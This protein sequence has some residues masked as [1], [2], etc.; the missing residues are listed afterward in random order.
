MRDSGAVVRAV[1]GVEVNASIVLCHG[2][3]AVVIG[4]YLE[5]DDLAVDSSEAFEGEF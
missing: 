4:E 5:L 3:F 1:L 2:Y